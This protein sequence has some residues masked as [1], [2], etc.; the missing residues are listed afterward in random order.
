[1]LHRR[2]AIIA[3]E[4]FVSLIRGFLQ[5]E[6]KQNKLLTR[7][8]L[9]YYNFA[10]RFVLVD[11]PLTA[12]EQSISKLVTIWAKNNLNRYCEE[13]LAVIEEKSEE[14]YFSKLAAPYHHLNGEAEQGAVDM[15]SR[16]KRIKE[17]G[18][19]IYQTRGLAKKKMV[20]ALTKNACY[21]QLDTCFHITENME[22][23]AS[24]AGVVTIYLQ[25]KVGRPII[26]LVQCTFNSAKEMMHVMVEFY[27]KVDLDEKLE[28]LKEKYGN[29]KDIAVN[30]YENKINI[31]L[32]K[33]SISKYGNHIRVE[34]EKFLNELK[35]MDFDKAKKI[36]NTIYHDALNAM[37]LKRRLQLSM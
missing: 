26:K 4:D 19:K 33:E 21:I 12:S 3:D 14:Y 8:C 27:D 10:K 32:K 36:T 16:W 17:L 1:L 5:E 15:V 13:S 11:L 2:K 22:K 18:A 6:W 30:T 34:V 35:S 29:I 23:L 25:A 31:K 28:Y 20:Q 24:A 37:K 7:A 9:Q